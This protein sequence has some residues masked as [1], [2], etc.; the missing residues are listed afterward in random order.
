MSYPHTYLIRC[1]CQWTLTDLD[2]VLAISNPNQ[3]HPQQV[4]QVREERSHYGTLWSYEIHQKDEIRKYKKYECRAQMIRQIQNHE[5]YAR[6]M[7]CREGSEALV[8]I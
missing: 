4:N 7:F 8:R 2:L 3:S 1:K 6:N 5:R